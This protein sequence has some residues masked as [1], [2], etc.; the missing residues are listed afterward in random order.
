MS[1]SLYRQ[2]PAS[3]RMFR[4]AQKGAEQSP[5]S[6]VPFRGKYLSFTH[7]LVSMSTDRIVPPV[8]RDVVLA[9][10]A[11][12]L[13]TVPLWIPTIHLIDPPYRYE[14]V[15]V[16]SNGSNVEYATEFP[17]SDR[18][19]ISDRIACSG[20]E[21]EVRTC[22]FERGVLQGREV[23]TEM[24]SHDPDWSLTHRILYLDHDRPPSEDYRYVR[25][26][27]TIY[28]PTVEATDRPAPGTDGYRVVL[29]LDQVAPANALRNVSLDADSEAVPTP[30][31][32]AARTGEARSYAA[33]DVPDTTIRVEDGSYRRVY[34]A[35]FDG[36]GSNDHW[37]NT[38]LNVG[39]P[40]LGLA[41]LGMLWRRFEISYVGGD[42]HR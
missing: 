1:T 34:V 25:L 20:W 27:D 23:P 11:L 3:S 37:V 40:V 21:Y 31:S 10:L 4:S 38:L 41:L 36:T 13:L 17:S 16:T 28:R 14:A 2:G 22:S 8:G 39:P 19:P 30:V 5:C 12:G 6:F 32:E 18:T 9:I 42:S 26:N 33:V 24:S 35:A 7:L 29:G 15:E